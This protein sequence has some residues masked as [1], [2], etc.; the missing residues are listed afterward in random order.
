MA[1]TAAR[2]LRHL[3][4]D[5]L[6]S[7]RDG[8]GDIVR[9]WTIMQGLWLGGHWADFLLDKTTG[10]HRPPQDFRMARTIRPPKSPLRRALVLHAA[11][12]RGLPQLATGHVLSR[13]FYVTQHSGDHL[14]RMRDCRGAFRSTLR[15]DAYRDLVLVASMITTFDTIAVGSR[16]YL[17]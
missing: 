17:F 3:P 5:W 6:A 14:H 11:K 10:L 1:C 8:A 9:S 12:K 4:A 7:A 2:H 16:R 15:F 13:T